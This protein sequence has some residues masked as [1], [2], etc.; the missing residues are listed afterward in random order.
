MRVNWTS[1]SPWL[2]EAFR[3]EGDFARP[4]WTQ[5]FAYLLEQGKK[6]AFVY[7]DK[8]YLCV[9]SMASAHSGI[10]SELTSTSELV[11]W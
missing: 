7:G 1:G 11:R 9:S 5:K 6:V 3:R 10:G 8:D 4:G 2:A